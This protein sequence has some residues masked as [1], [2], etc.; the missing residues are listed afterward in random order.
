[1][2]INQNVIS[3]IK[4]ISFVYIYPSICSFFFY[5]A[6]FNLSNLINYHMLTN[7]TKFQFPSIEMEKIG[8]VLNLV[9]GSLSPK[10][11]QLRFKNYN[12]TPNCL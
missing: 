1:M 10:K 2:N 11:R 5:F 8:K 9:S 6:S 12:V 3:I 7:K 4:F